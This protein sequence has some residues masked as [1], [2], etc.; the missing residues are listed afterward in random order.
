MNINKTTQKLPAYLDF[1][2]GHIYNDMKQCEKEDK[3]IACNLRT[4]FQ[5]R[6]LI[7]SL[8][9]ELKM[10]QD[11]MQFGISF[12]NQIEETALTIGS[13]SRYDILDICNN[14]I[15]RAK[16]KYSK[17]YTSITFHNQD[18]RSVTATH[19]YDAVICFMLLSQV[20]SASKRK[21]INNALKLVKKGGKVIFIDWHTPLF[22]HPLRYIVRMY[23]RLNHPFVERLWDRD[24]SSYA[25]TDLRSRF[26]WRKTTYFGR[27]FQ[28]CVAT[29][30]DDPLNIIKQST[31]N[32]DD[33]FADQYSEIVDD[34]SLLDG[35]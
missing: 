7:N 6:L 31:S 29:R 24:I 34:N 25:E 14:E 26:S 20:P 27:M 33:F 23:N 11:V 22:Y 35:F 28:K 21:I 18:V 32:G 1:I 15:D 4:F 9:K 16:E 30:K 13:F 2:Y 12:G 17:I 19:T 8:N 5:Y 10:N 3:I